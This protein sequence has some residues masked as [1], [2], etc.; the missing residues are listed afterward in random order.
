[1][2]RMKRRRTKSKKTTKLTISKESV[3][4]LGSLGLSNVVGADHTAHCDTITLKC[5]LTR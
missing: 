1:M 4:M 5:C 3:R 2:H